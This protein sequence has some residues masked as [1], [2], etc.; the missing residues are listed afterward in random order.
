MR[1]RILLK[2]PSAVILSGG[3][4]PKSKPVGRAQRRISRRYA[5]GISH[6]YPPENLLYAKNAMCNIIPPNGINCNYGK[7]KL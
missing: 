6:K 5:A 3:R 1:E 7:K 2:I 4:S